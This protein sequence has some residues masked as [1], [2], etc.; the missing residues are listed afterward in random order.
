M[1]HQLHTDLDQDGLDDLHE[2]ERGVDASPQP[3]DLVGLWQGVGR[4]R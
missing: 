1:P 3:C 2:E 4:E